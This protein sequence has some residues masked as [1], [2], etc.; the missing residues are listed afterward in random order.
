MSNSADPDQLASSEGG[1]YLGSTGQGLIL[2][3]PYTSL[4]QVHFKCV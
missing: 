2:S 3:L 4:Q 1:V